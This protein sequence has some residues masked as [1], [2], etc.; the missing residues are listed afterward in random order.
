MSSCM[1][2][3][4][5]DFVCQENKDTIENFVTLNPA[6]TPFGTYLS[7]CKNCGFWRSADSKVNKLKCDCLKSN[8]KYNEKTE[9]PNCFGN[10]V[11]NNGNLECQ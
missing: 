6:P 4:Q 3:A 5:G 1:Y 8:K 2:S 7:S 11:N 10:I 9:L